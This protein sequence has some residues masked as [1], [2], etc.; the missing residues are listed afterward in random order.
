MEKK[1]CR[2]EKLSKKLLMNG[3]IIMGK[4]ILVTILKKYF[5]KIDQFLNHN[6]VN[7]RTIIIKQTFSRIFSIKI[8]K[9]QNKTFLNQHFLK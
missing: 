7:N 6:K 5:R 8:L 4:K 3:D 2:K 9:V 1:L